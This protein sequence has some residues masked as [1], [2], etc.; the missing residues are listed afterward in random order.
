M[1]ALLLVYVL[2]CSVLF[3]LWLPGPETAYRLDQDLLLPLGL[4]GTLAALLARRGAEGR[5][6]WAWTGMLAAHLT[7]V[8]ALIAE[9]LHV[10]LGGPVRE[11]G[12]VADLLFALISP[13]MVA[14]LL[15][16]P[17]APALARDRLKLVIDVLTLALAAGM[18]GW[19]GLVRWP[20][21]AAAR[22]GLPLPP[23]GPDKLAQLAGGLVFVVLGALVLLAPATPRTVRPA[24]WLLFAGFLFGLSVLVFETP[25]GQLPALQT[26]KL[27]SVSG[28]A[29]AEL[30]FVLA[31]L[32]QWQD[33]TRRAD[34]LLDNGA[35]L[36]AALPYGALITLYL[37]FFAS[38]PGDLRMREWSAA[39]CFT[40]TLLMLTRQGLVI[41]ENV[42]IGVALRERTLALEESDRRKDELLT[43]LAHQARHDAL[44]GLLG[45]AAF[46]AHLEAAVRQASLTGEGLAV[47]F[48]DLD[49][50]KAVNDTLGHA[51]GDALLREVAVRLRGAVPPPGLVA[52]LSGDEFT[53]LLP[54][55]GGQEAERVAQA[56]IKGL[57]RP[58]LLA[59]RQ[60]GVTGSVGLSVYPADATDADT[61]LGH[62][63]TAMYHAKARG[64]NAWRAYTPE[65]D[66]AAGI[67]PL[68]RGAAGR[69]E[70]TLHY[71]PQFDTLGRR[72]LALEALLRWT[73]PE[74]GPVDP[75]RFIPVAEDSGLIVEIGA[76]VLDEACR[77]NA[78][79]QR[80]GLAPVRVAVN[81]SPAQ[82]A[83]EAF[84]AEVG[85][86]LRRHALAGTWLELEVTERLALREVERAV[87]VLRE[88]RRL[89]VRVA[90]DDFGQGHSSLG[91]LAHLPLDVLK[92][93]RALIQ[94]LGRA[95]QADRVT[96]AV[97]ALGR[98]LG[99]EVVAEGVETPAQLAAAA[100]LGCERTQGFL[101]GRPLP[102]AEIEPHLRLEAGQ[103]PIQEGA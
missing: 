42:Q 31:A 85:D 70:F 30:C 1:A 81:V 78:A 38:F 18:A 88:V 40:A 43:A 39:A 46:T 83:R 79:W 13:P 60:A 20:Q 5:T 71:Q 99:L 92:V 9:S 32:R 89:G 21:E 11:D 24:R 84:A 8:A 53:A 63:D 65:M 64:K 57:S 80:A 62:A 3:T 68:L 95:A 76:W 54:G 102:A 75:G 69:G 56:I 82:L 48:V 15:L 72:V 58:Y 87:A 96:Q 14:G 7:L 33:A 4:L 98:G 93:D 10:H 77:Q 73:H 61:L 45:R 97:V 49:G 52:R 91:H 50:F 22:W 74:L 37:L 86:T 59:G 29:L 17:S 67:G 27:L 100:A 94:D 23:L 36:S 101:L 26:H 47:L 28:W 25:L 90:L 16:L 44:T 2:L 51:A 41:H 103:K 66:P 34:L 55:L 35:L 19:A 12:P 6:R